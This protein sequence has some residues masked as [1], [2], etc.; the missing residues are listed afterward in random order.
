MAFSPAWA[1]QPQEKA[2]LQRQSR[3]AEDDFDKALE[4]LWIHGGALVDFAE[5]VTRGHDHWRETYTAQATRSSS[6]ST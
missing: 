6:S 2:A 4:K 5:N 3:M 1:P